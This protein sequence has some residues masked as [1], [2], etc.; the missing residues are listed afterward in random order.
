MAD[1]VQ[2]VLHA[3]AK[4][5]LV[6]A[7]AGVP[8]HAGGRAHL[9][10]ADGLLA[11]LGGHVLDRGADRDV[12]PLG[13]LAQQGRRVGRGQGRRPTAVTFAEHGKLPSL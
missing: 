7:L 10:E 6:V 8:L 3:F 5:E 11:P 2:E 4:G 12:V 13:H 9:Q 1:T